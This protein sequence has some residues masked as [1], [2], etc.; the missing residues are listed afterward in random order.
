[1]QGGSLPAEPPEPISIPGSTRK[2]APKEIDDLNNPPDWFPDQ[3]PPS[4]AV[5]QK[6]G[7]RGCSH[8][9]AVI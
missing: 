5:V 6:G 9:E 8:A 3:H 7:V 2:Y 4:P 1:M